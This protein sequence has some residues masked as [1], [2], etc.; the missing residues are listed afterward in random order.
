M[1]LR[2]IYLSLDLQTAILTLMHKASVLAAVASGG[3]AR[4]SDTNSYSKIGR[5]DVTYLRR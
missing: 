1:D 5:G 4:V 2:F 3:G